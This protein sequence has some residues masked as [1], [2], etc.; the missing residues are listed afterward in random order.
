MYLLGNVWLPLFSRYLAKLLSF[1]WKMEW[2]LG[3]IPYLYM[4]RYC[5]FTIATVFKSLLIISRDHQR[6]GDHWM[7]HI[8]STSGVT[9]WWTEDRLDWNYWQVCLEFWTKNFQWLKK[10]VKKGNKLKAKKKQLKS[11]NLRLLELLQKRF[12]LDKKER[13]ETKLSL[14]K[15]WCSGQVFRTFSAPR[16]SFK[17]WLQMLL[18][19]EV[20]WGNDQRP[21]EPRESDG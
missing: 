11:V 9:H 1:L 14:E 21:Q 15:S 7:N 6:V 17:I 8:L 18:V 5:T 3:V 19:T 12:I 16:S 13:I 4:K 10:R 2:S 20:K